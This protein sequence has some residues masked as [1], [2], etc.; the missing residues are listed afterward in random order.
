MENY[1]LLSNESVLYKGDVSL[2]SRKG[3]TAELILTN[4]N[5]VLMIKS[6][7]SFFANIETEVEVYPVDTIKVYEGE[8]QLKQSDVELEI[9]FT[10][11]EI[12]VSFNSKMELM[13][14][15]LTATKLITGKSIQERGAD[16]VKGAINLVNNTLGV[17]TV[18]TVKGVFENGIV[19]SVLGGF[20]KKSAS[21]AKAMI[22][23]AGIAK[24]AIGLADDFVYK[25]SASKTEVNK[26]SYE[27]QLEAVKKFKELLDVGVISQ[28]EFDA[29]KKEI[30]KQ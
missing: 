8:P 30:L 10:T 11:D 29:K 18:Q 16:K 7:K 2:S 5:V 28:E 23:K 27:K 15:K 4:L 12:K 24:E 14:F 17:D 6:K 1:K 9:F 19:G 20:G 21:P 13:K 25:D 22:S 26:L 3:G